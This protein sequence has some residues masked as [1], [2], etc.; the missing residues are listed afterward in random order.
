MI[1][2]GLIKLKIPCSIGLSGNRSTCD[3]EL[4]TRTRCACGSTSFLEFRDFLHKTISS[5]LVTFID[6][7]DY[8]SYRSD[9]TFAGNID[10]G[11]PKL[12]E[13]L[14]KARTMKIVC[15]LHILDQR[16]LPF[17]ELMDDAP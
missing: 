11:S 15:S 14:V 16:P 1:T 5:R 12:V 13:V 6:G 9:P 3:E 7:V 8:D 17:N 4:Y 2:L 10:E